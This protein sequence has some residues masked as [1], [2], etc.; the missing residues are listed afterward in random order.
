MKSG[1]E[2][3]IHPPIPP[4]PPIPS[5]YGV[6]PEYVKKRAYE[7]PNI[8]SINIS[9]LF[10][11]MPKPIYPPPDP[12]AIREATRK[13]LEKVDMSMIKP[14]H[15]VNILGSHHGFTLLGGEPYAEMLKTIKDVVEEKTG[16]RD[17]RL[18]LGVG[19]RHRENEIYIRR[20]KLDEYFNGKAF[21]V[22]PL[23]PGIPI[24][25]E[26]GTFYGIRQIYDAD[27][28][29][30]A[31]NSDVREVHFHRHVDRAFKPFGM[32]YARLETR[33]AY[34]QNLGPRGSN[35]VARA[36]FN[37]KFVQE[38]WTFAS[39]LRASPIG[40]LGVYADNNLDR[41]DK[42]LL[43]DNLRYYGAVM[44]LL[45]KIDECIA[46]L[47]FRSPV[48]YVF[49]GGVIFANFT[50]LNIDLFDLDNPLPPYTWYTEA[51]Y[52]EFNRPIIP[53]VPPVNPAIKAIVINYAW[54][55]YPSVFWPKNIPTIIVGRKQADVY[56]IDPQNAEF[57]KYAVIA[58][59][60]EAAMEFAYKIAKT[61]KVLIFDGV[62]GSINMSKSLAEYLIEK[63]PEVEEE[64]KKRLPKWLKQRGLTAEEIKDLAKY[65]NEPELEEIA[66]LF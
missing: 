41:L 44:L 22:S 61:D 59:D 49:A 8:V 26:I 54:V 15:K 56:K 27:K 63:V 40:I 14:H 7:L 11:W 58:E 3:L 53:E 5:P 17:V 28:I 23:D 9:E 57:L 18:V 42:K 66:K 2:A 43:I 10:P 46:V 65:Y 55:G 1:K 4:L 52:D 19:L 51:Y 48:P 16:A 36:I 24:E 47:D 62:Y 25:T 30:H 31:H 50:G 6:A 12:K 39:F 37:S 33:S 34:H 45:S 29:V 20:F 60:L 32:S 35:F 38:K 21:N 64:L 13:A